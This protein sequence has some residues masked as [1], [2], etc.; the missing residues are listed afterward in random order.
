[1]VASLEFAMP[2]VQRKLSCEMYKKDGVPEKQRIK[3]TGHAIKRFLQR[4]ALYK[5]KR[6]QA[7]A[8][9]MGC[10]DEAT[11]MYRYIGKEI[12]DVHGV[13]YNYLGEFE[14][15]K[16][17]VLVSWL[18]CVYTV[19]TA[20][21]ADYSNKG[22]VEAYMEQYAKAEEEAKAKIEKKEL[23]KKQWQEQKRGGEQ[24]V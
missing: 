23:A 11:R 24:G 10:L 1:M 22:L 6:S 15:K 2:D 4:V 12:N 5:I 7:E 17:V 8:E 14:G 20:S 16:Y 21:M 3:P 13:T 19:L 9:I 18:G